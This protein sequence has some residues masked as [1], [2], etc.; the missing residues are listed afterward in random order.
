MTHRDI[1]QLKE[2]HKPW[3]KR[4]EMEISDLQIPCKP[5]QNSN[6]IFHRS[7]INNPKICMVP[8]KNLNSQNYHEIEEQSWSLFSFPDFTLYYKTT[9]IK[10]LAWV[11][12]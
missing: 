1:F 4:T 12:K 9:V 11:Q 6:G 5:Y 10:S 3:E 7:R 2:Q 8:V